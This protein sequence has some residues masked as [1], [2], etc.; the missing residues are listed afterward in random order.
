MRE[1]NISIHPRTSVFGHG[2]KLNTAKPT[3]RRKLERQ[4]R[5]IEGHLEKHP[6]DLMS[7]GRVNI[8]KAMLVD[9]R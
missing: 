8:I 4:L 6:D 5:G 3:S 9:I 1:N 7:Q 2:P